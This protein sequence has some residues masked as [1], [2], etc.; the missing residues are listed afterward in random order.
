MQFDFT[1][2]DT[3]THLLIF[4]AIIDVNEPERERACYD[5]LKNPFV[6]VKRTLLYTNK[7]SIEYVKA[8]L[9]VVASYVCEENCK[10]NYML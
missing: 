7:P 6:H 9:Y 1:Q 4:N 2:D 3:Q 10:P 5:S 8:G